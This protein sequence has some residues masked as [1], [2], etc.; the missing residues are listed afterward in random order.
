MGLRHCI[1]V[2]VDTTPADGDTWLE[3][4][5]SDLAEEIVGLALYEAAQLYMDSRVPT[6]DI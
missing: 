5:P 4:E 6:D 1:M 3:V 2:W